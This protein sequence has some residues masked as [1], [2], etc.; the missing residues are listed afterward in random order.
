L[1]SAD[2]NAPRTEVPAPSQAAGC[3]RTARRV[4]ARRWPPA[5]PGCAARQGARPPDSRSRRV[6][7][8]RTSKPT[9][10]CSQRPARRPCALRSDDTEAPSGVAAGLMSAGSAFL[11]PHLVRCGT[12][13]T[14]GPWT[15]PPGGCSP[16]LSHPRGD[17]GPPGAT[18]IGPQGRRGG[19]RERSDG[20]GGLGR[21]SGSGRTDV[22]SSR[23]GRSGR[24]PTEPRARRGAADGPGRQRIPGRSIGV[25]ETARS[26]GERIDRRPGTLTRRRLGVVS[27]ACGT[28][29]PGSYVP[30][31]R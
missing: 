31:Q 28:S 27:G 25:G 8:T 22:R 10:G 21:T 19:G 7:P 29:L 17:G 15:C 24:L 30:R 12:A 18:G 4:P 1:T 6:R 16:K 23:P 13:A 20:G 5:R 3:G 9:G 11:R 14:L 2:P 26:A